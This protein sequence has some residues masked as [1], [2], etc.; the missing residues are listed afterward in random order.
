MVGIGGIVSVGG[1]GGGG[2]SGSSSGITS[3]NGATGPA[4]VLA[5]VSGVS[6]V[7]S[8]NTILIG[9]ENVTGT[10]TGTQSGV[11]GV[12]GVQVHQ[13]G[14]EFVVDAAPLSGIQAVEI[15]PVFSYRATFASVTDVTFN[16]GFGSNEVIAQFFDNSSP[17]QVMI[18]D[19][20]IATDADNLRALFNVPV[21]GSVVIHSPSGNAANIRLAVGGTE[22]KAIT[23]E[24]PTASEDISLFWTDVPITMRKITSVLT[25]TIDASGVFSIRHGTDR[26]AAGTEVV[27]G[28][29]STTSRT[30]GDITSS[31]DS[32]VIPASSFLW[33]E[34]TSVSGTPATTTM[35][36][37][38]VYDKGS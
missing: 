23:I 33:L 15:S 6:V 38:L 27:T 34:T 28:G 35:N 4:I 7:P 17:A 30:A 18:P 3:I 5:G 14:G 11:V 25:G 22:S 1:A 21:T 13:I 36:V 10:G 19:K 2:G 9:G 26:S 16:H 29:I 32:P 12:N 24:S 31:F 37:S 20:V 8:G